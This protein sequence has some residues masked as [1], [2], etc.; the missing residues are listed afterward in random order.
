STAAIDVNTIVVGAN[1]ATVGTNSLQGA[2]Y[3]FTRDGTT[4]TQQ[5]KL[6]SL[7]G[8]AQDLFGISVAIAGN[9]VVVGASLDDVGPNIDQGSA[10]VFFRGGT[11]WTQQVQL[12]S[13][14]GM[15]GDLFGRSLAIS[16]NKMLVG[17]SDTLG[18]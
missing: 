11:A 14:D 16:G 17:A 12:N 2:A 3:V 8:T 4:W 18:D 1:R 7:D 10:Y 5:A 15:I 13:T 6:T 9:T